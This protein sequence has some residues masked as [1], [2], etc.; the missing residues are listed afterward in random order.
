MHY[1]KML[2]WIIGLL[3]FSCQDT[4]TNINEPDHIAFAPPQAVSIQGYDGH[5]MEPFLSRDGSILFFNNLNAPTENTNL[6]WSTKINDTL[7]QYQGELDNVNTFFSN[8]LFGN[9]FRKPRVFKGFS[10]KN[11]GFPKKMI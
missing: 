9:S 2:I 6:H 10:S 1:T 7:F 4:P 3:C 5:I 8:S 11:R